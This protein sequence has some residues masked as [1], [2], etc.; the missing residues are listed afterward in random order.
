MVEEA[1][2]HHQVKRGTPTG[3]SILINYTLL[4]RSESSFAVVVLVVAVVVVFGLVV[5]NNNNNNNV[6]LLFE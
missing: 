6:L 5:N 2:K 1:K 4:G 3:S